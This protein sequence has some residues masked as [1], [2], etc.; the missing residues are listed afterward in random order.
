LNLN[1]LNM[2]KQLV[3]F[4]TGAFAQVAYFYFKH[5]SEYEVV[6]FT[7]NEEKIEENELLG[8]PVT[9]FE[10]IES[11]YPAEKYDLFL[12]IGYTKL[13]KIRAELYNSI[14]EKGYKLATYVHSKIHIWPNNKIGENTF[15]F[16]DNTIQPFVEIGNNVVLWS[17]NHI[18]HHSIIGDHCFLTSHVVV[19]GFVNMGRY[20]F[21]GVNATLRDSITIGEKC[22]LGAGTL[23]L[24][25]TQPNEVYIGPK[26]EPIPKESSEIKRF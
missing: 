25:D 5:D 17:G 11:N 6:A 14:K 12:A 26:S 19:S 20:C 1:K 21:L 4:G 8:L 7:A 22:I 3:I 2:D 18:G 9:P 23:I 10:N 13:N 16:E 15:I 24:K